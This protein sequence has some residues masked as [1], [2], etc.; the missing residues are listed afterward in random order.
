VPESKGQHDESLES[1]L[2]YAGAPAMDTRKRQELVYRTMHIGAWARYFPPKNQNQ[3]E[4]LIAVDK[5]Q[6]LWWQDEFHFMMTLDSIKRSKKLAHKKSKAMGLQYERIVRLVG[7]AF[8]DLASKKG[9]TLSE[10]EL[11]DLMYGEKGLLTK[12]V[13]YGRLHAAK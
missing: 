4:I 9:K 5:V 11:N 7:K 12:A 10:S 6:R 8:N 1:S 2:G 3:R 13:E